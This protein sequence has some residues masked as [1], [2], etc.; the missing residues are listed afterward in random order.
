MRGFST[1]DN[2]WEPS[3]IGRP[4]WEGAP[5]ASRGCCRPQSG[6][7]VPACAAA[8]HSLLM[9]PRSP[10]KPLR[11]DREELT[12]HLRLACPSSQSWYRA[13]VD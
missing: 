12:A 13:V 5:P 9:L 6:S 11:V 2:L 10:L 7:A 4:H 3:K 8:S 1:E